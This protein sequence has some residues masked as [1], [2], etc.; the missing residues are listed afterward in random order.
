MMS[1][2]FL[3][4]G[5]AQKM[6]F[7]DAS[8]LVKSYPVCLR[9][10]AAKDNRKGQVLDVVWGSLLEQGDVFQLVAQREY[11]GTRLWYP[12]GL[13]QDSIVFMKPVKDL[14]GTTRWAPSNYR[15]EISRDRVSYDVRPVYPPAKDS[16]GRQRLEL[17]VDRIRFRA[18]LARNNRE[19]MT[20]PEVKAELVRLRLKVGVTMPWHAPSPKLR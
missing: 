12:A 4:L 3:A 17:V 18:D 11:P 15:I 20:Y 9:V 10:K 13:S 5:L 16:A 8:E 6:A 7:I 2:L 19:H 1:L 14:G